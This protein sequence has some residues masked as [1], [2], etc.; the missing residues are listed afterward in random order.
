MD[1]SYFIEKSLRI[2]FVIFA[3]GWMFNSSK[4]SI[5]ALL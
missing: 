4:S 5:F 1:C 3:P 2:S